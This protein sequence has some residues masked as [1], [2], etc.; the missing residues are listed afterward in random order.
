MIKLNTMLKNKN[1][2]RKI[3]D[4]Y[5]KDEKTKDKYT[6]IYNNVR[7]YYKKKIKSNEDFIIESVYIDSEL[8]KYSNKNENIKMALVSGFFSAIVVELV[9]NQIPT[10]YQMFESIINVIK[11]NLTYISSITNLKQILVL[12]I[13]FI[14]LIF[15]LLIATVPIIFPVIIIDLA[16]KRPINKQN[17]LIIYYSICREILDELKFERDN[18]K[19]Y[20]HGKRR[21]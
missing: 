14:V 20:K 5:I 18:I 16:Y 10:M 13:T 6:E 1:K 4:L 7:D 12:L 11:L 17:E 21:R 2:W 9:S 19:N 8:N 3:H 15:M